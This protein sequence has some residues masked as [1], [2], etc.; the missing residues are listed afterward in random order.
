MITM[1][2]K[3]T[4]RNTC[5]LL[6]AL[7]CTSIADAKPRTFQQMEEAAMEA[8]AKM[9]S[10]RRQA[11]AVIK[12]TATQST[13][14]YTVFAREGGGYAIVTS[15]DLAPAVIGL[16]EK[17]YNTENENFKWWLK[18]ADEAVRYIVENNVSVTATPPEDLDFPKSVAPM[19]TTEWDQS[20]PYNNYAPRAQSERCLTGCVATAMAQ[21]LNYFKSPVKGRGQR[22]ITYPYRSKNGQ[23]VKAAFEEH[24]YD[25]DHML[26][27]YRFVSY[28]EEE[29]HAVAELMR[30][31]GVAANMQY[32]VSAA[33]G[34]GAYSEN[35]ATGLRT[36]F[37]MVDAK[38][39]YR[40][41]YSEKDWMR[42]VYNELSNNRPVYYGG[43]SRS[44][45]GHA[46]VLHGYNAAG[47][48]YV[49]WGWSGDDDGYYDIALLNPG[50]YRFSEGQDMIIGVYPQP[51]EFEEMTVS[52]NTPGTLSGLVPDDLIGV[53]GSLKVKG[54]INS[55]DLLQLRKLAGSDLTGERTGGWLQQLDLSEARIVAG[56]DE[57][58]VSSPI[59][60]DAP[61]VTE[62]DVLGKYAFYNC[63]TLRSLTLPKGLKRIAPSAFKGCFMLDELNVEGA[64]DKDFVMKDGIIYNKD[65]T[66]IVYATA[67]LRDSLIV[68][69]GVTTLGTDAMRECEQLEYVALPASLKTFGNESMAHCT[70]MKEL[71]V[72]SKSIPTLGNSVFSNVFV[73]ECDLYV[74]N[75][76]KNK[77]AQANQWSDFAY[78]D[79]FDNIYEFGTT[80]KARN[81]VRVYG[82]PTPVFGYQISGD[83]VEG[84]PELVCEAD[85]KSPAGRYPIKVLP[86]SITDS[87]VDYEDG[88]LIVQKA[89]LTATVDDATRARYDEDPVF[90][91]TYTGFKNN[92]DASVL[93]TK[94]VVVSTAKKDSPEGTYELTV[95]GGEDDCYEFKYVSGLL[96]IAGVSA[97]DGVEADGGKLVIRRLDG[98][99][100]PGGSVAGLPKGVYIVNGR[101]MVIK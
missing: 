38:C 14:N 23:K 84:T 26:D 28:S 47:L 51:T 89:E 65:M 56:G 46:F 75:G 45:G 11:P 83:L 53:V 74:R 76:M 60:S 80:I 92:E 13:D 25:W 70:H 16:S 43:S 72:A 1:N 33:G 99:L 30:D 100:V 73:M 49:N 2:M 81:A 86:G 44:S 69:D 10:N 71:R 36:Y 42:L 54:D 41:E 95:S 82:D 40:D 21:V 18:L 87:S 48:V 98:T 19:L 12:V 68:A 20:T 29:A 63:L 31:C 32:G 62:D 67:G 7:A 6:A 24:Y 15:D 27:K 79:Y 94:P 77:Y 57:Y 61:Y 90:T 52:V 97:I 35:A 91:I 8:F 37:G 58:F 4:F 66:E 3:R 5:L 50:F 17:A 59:S 9:S 64:A 96:T 34:S 93:D 85:E 39:V 88:F 22:T 101:K 78:E 55:S